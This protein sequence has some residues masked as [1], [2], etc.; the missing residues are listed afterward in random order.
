M[1]WFLMIVLALH[2]LSSV[3]WAGTAFVLARTGGP[4]AGRFFRPQVGAAIVAT[5]S[6]AVLWGLT[7][8]GG[9]GG[10]EKVLGFGIATAL[11]ASLV[12]GAGVGP[13][14]RAAGRGDV[15]APRVAVAYRPS[16]GLLMVTII[17]M[18]VARYV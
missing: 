12:Q 9:S 8:A 15:E 2:V 14:L 10:P 6:G 13:S 4:D 3:F 7:H 1:P 18:A 16:A 5:V 17:C 11:I